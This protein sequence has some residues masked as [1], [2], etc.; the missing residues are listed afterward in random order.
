M[1]EPMLPRIIQS[2]RILIFG[3]TGANGIKIEDMTSPQK[4]K[5]RLWILSAKYPKT[6]CKIFAA[7]LEMLSTTVAI[8]ID[9]PNL[10]EINGIIGLSMPVEISFTKCAPESHIRGCFLLNLIIWIL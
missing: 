9:M 8:A 5:A 1:L 10:A 3:A 2:I 4:I 6:G 7:I